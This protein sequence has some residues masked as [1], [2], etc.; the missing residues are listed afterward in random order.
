[1]LL[2]LRRNDF[3]Q[4]NR[5]RGVAVDDGGSAV[6]DLW[7][8]GGESS[9]QN[10]ARLDPKQ[11]QQFDLPQNSVLDQYSSEWF[12]SCKNF[13]GDGS[14]EQIQVQSHNSVL[15]DEPVGIAAQNDFPR[16]DI[17]VGRR[18]EDFHRNARSMKSLDGHCHVMFVREQAVERFIDR[19][20]FHR[21]EIADG[22]RIIVEQLQQRGEIDLSGRH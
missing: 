7:I 15:D 4:L 21:D 11:L 3:Q 17:V 5:W 16:I 20:R 2:H 1:M 12:L 18:L 10:W 8:V 14:G 19:G 22:I 13:I 6:A 9:F